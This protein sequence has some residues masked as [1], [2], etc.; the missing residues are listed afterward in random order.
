MAYLRRYSRRIQVGA[1]LALLGIVDLL[2]VVGGMGTVDP[3]Q[4]RQSEL[5]TIERLES[6]ILEKRE[7]VDSL[8]FPEAS[9]V[10][11]LVLNLAQGEGAGSDV[12]V[13]AFSTR[14][15]P[16]ALAGSTFPVIQNTM[17]MKGSLHGLLAT[18]RRLHD[19]PVRTVTVGSLQGTRSLDIWSLKLVVKVYTGEP[20]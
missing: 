2:L 3:G 5:E 16:E 9:E 12:Q 6:Q 8:A 19:A 14:D 18:L 1:L 13:V 20:S 17:E 11:N 4:Q 15:R 7:Y 10:R